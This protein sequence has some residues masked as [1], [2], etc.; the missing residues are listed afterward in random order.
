MATSRW[1]I[2]R[3]L[4][5]G[6]SLELVE[7]FDNVAGQCNRHE[8][9]RE[10]QSLLVAQG[11]P[12]THCSGG[13]HC[14]MRLSEFSHECSKSAPQRLPGRPQVAPGCLPE[15]SQLPCNN[16]VCSYKLHGAPQ[17]IQDASRRP[18]R[19]FPEAVRDVQMLLRV[20]RGTRRSI[21]ST[22]DTQPGNRHTPIKKHTDT[23]HKLPTIRQH[24]GEE[25]ITTQT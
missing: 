4:S 2:P 15:A 17:E 5:T 14:Q 9:G 6:V 24:P 10:G 16:T 12:P 23:F 7:A 11:P 21:I 13:A 25:W 3:I 18:P 20:L 22:R 8:C 1:P 19:S